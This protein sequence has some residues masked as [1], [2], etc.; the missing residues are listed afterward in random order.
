MESPRGTFS[1]NPG[2]GAERAPQP[3]RGDGD[4]G[5]MGL[6]SE[7]GGRA[8]HDGA[9]LR[10]RLRAARG[11]SGDGAATVRSGGV[12]AAR[13]GGRLMQGAMPRRRAAEDRFPISCTESGRELVRKMA[14]GRILVTLRGVHYHYAMR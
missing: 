5:P 3:A 2:S 8:R 13:R 6:G 1:C 9:G 11:V 10:G 12:P 4:G 14:Y 7:R